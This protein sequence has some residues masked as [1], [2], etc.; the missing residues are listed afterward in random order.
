MKDAAKNE[1]ASFAAKSAKLKAD[2]DA[3]FAQRKMREALASYEKALTMCPSGTEERAAIHSNRA[4]CYLMENQYQMAI[5]EAS[6]A[7]ESTPGFK[8]A[9][10]RRAGAFER[11]GLYDRAVTDLESAL[12]VDADDSTRKK[13]ATVKAAANN[14]R[15]SR[16][17]GRGVGLG[18]RASA[19]AARQQQRLTPAQQQAA[20]AAAA[21]RNQQMPML[22]LNCTL[23]ETTKKIVLPIS[24]PYKDV[25][26]S[27]KAS[28]P[29]CGDAVALKFRDPEG[30]LI[31][32]TSRTDLRSALSAAVTAAEARAAATGKAAA[33]PP[34]GIAPLE[35]EVVKV[36]KAVSETPDQVTPP[37]V[38]A[39][40]STPEH[41]EDAAPDVVE[42]DEWLLGFAAMFRKQ[43]GDA[44]PAA[45]E[46]DL[47]EIGLEK[48]CE[49]LEAAVGEPKAKE[50]FED[51]TKKFEEAAAAALFNWGNVYVCSTRKLVDAAEPPES[52]DVGS[53]QLPS[54][55]AMKT[56]AEKHLARVDADFDKAVDRY[57]ESLA[58]RSNFYESTIAWGQ[59]AFERGKVY[60]VASKEKNDASHRKTADE[61]FKLAE[62]KFLESIALLPEE[63]ARE[64]GEAEGVLNLKSQIQVLHG[65]VLFERSQ[66]RHH[67]GDD[68]WEEDTVAAVEKFTAA[69]CDKNDVI[70]AL[71]NHTSKKWKEDEEAAVAMA[72]GK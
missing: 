52:A 23:G 64:P 14:A 63:E 59:Q 11:L 15:A 39:A 69:G 24:V 49:A 56:T 67:R 28:F 31:T 22:T 34:G 32:V 72:G 7:L 10:V 44:A 5:R 17:A 18:P 43:L 68:A 4:A 16:G 25:V 42:I 2:G 30:D 51:A 3:K 57:K 8:P 61:M 19:A 41:G 45:G 47:R 58:L 1:I 35:I 33:V 20:A 66:V 27:V 71:M 6:A 26:A 12:K 40:G 37:H 38:G 21:Q 13:L 60:H 53:D 54:E 55:A 9:L 29:E 48:C 50:L 70:R 65:N 36:P 46:L 62:E